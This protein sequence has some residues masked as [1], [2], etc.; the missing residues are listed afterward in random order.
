[1]RTPMK[2]WYFTYPRSIGTVVVGYDFGFFLEGNYMVCGNCKT[3][4]MALERIAEMATNEPA[5]IV[6]EDTPS[7]KKHG[8][9]CTSRNPQTLAAVPV[10][11]K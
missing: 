2:L 8:Q 6:N 5:G 4:E 10:R 9:R 11:L 1:M 7:L 3:R